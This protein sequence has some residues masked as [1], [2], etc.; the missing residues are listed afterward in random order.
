MIYH[1]ILPSGIRIR[2]GN[3]D[4]ISI[5]RPTFD[6]PRRNPTRRCATK[7][8]YAT[9]VTAI[10]CTCR[11]VYLEAS[12]ILCKN[13][14]FRYDPPKI[15]PGLLTP[16]DIPSNRRRAE[17][18]LT[19]P[20]MKYLPFARPLLSTVARFELME[21]FSH[22]IDP[23][24][25][26]GYDSTLAVELLARY[27]TSL[28][29]LLVSLNSLAR[30]RLYLETF[31]NLMTRLPQLLNTFATLKTIYFQVTAPD[32]VG[33]SVIPVIR[34]CAKKTAEL[35]TWAYLDLSSIEMNIEDDSRN[36]LEPGLN[37]RGRWVLRK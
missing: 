13:L 15:L 3:P 30:A 12:D 24:I 19:R 1:L 28:K 35:G 34:R 21:V 14:V 11:Q 16:Y 2:D 26:P 32:G 17:L 18:S 6:R 20:T 31:Y 7:V 22:I 25:E 29:V 9:K 4:S 5:N 33:R 27:A 10:L 36:P 8:I 23:S 37:H